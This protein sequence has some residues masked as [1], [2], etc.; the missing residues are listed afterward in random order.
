VCVEACAVG[1]WRGYSEVGDGN[2]GMQ[3]APSPLMQLGPGLQVPAVTG[4]CL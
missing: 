2:M 4:S 1:M 3:V